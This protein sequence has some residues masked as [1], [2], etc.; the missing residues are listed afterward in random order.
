MSSLPLPCARRSSMSHF[1]HLETVSLYDG[2]FLDSTLQ[3]AL[4]TFGIQCSHGAADPFCKLCVHPPILVPPGA[5][6]G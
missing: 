2:D 1:G 6:A 3:D 4:D 5:S